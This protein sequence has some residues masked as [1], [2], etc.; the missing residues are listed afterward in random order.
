LLIDAVGDHRAAQFVRVNAAGVLADG[1]Y[2]AAGDSEDFAPDFDVEAARLPDGYSV[3]IRLPFIALALP[4]PR[5]RGRGM[6]S[7]GRTQ[8]AARVEHAA[9]VGAADQGRAVVHRCVAGDRKPR[10]GDATARASRASSCCA[11]S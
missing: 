11:P 6:A 3:E 8:R 10:R 9:A 2:N 5:W 7:D 4:P 1:L